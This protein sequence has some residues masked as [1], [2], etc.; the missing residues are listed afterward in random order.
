MAFAAGA[1]LIANSPATLSVQVAS[2]LGL[3][4]QSIQALP[5][6]TSRSLFMG[7]QA[8]SYFPVTVTVGGSF[9]YLFCLGESGGARHSRTLRCQGQRLRSS[10]GE[11]PYN[12][13]PGQ[14]FVGSRR[15]APR[16]PFLPRLDEFTGVCA[17]TH[18]GQ[19]AWAA[20][21]TTQP[22]VSRRL[23]PPYPEAP[24]SRLYPDGAPRR[25][26]Q[27]TTRVIWPG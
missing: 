6:P 8:K 21:L 17:S 15:E 16:I 11:S 26:S 1:L 19:V 4:A 24:R 23:S 22:A 27:S 25:G 18:D 20:G 5:P 3:V 9:E 10:S 2:A 12:S 13:L 14:A 7:R